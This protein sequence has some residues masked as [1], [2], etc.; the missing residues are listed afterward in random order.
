MK[1]RGIAVSESRIIFT[2][3]N[4]V[5]VCKRQEPNELLFKILGPF[6][7]PRGVAMDE[8]EYIYVA[9]SNN[10]R[11]VKFHRDGRYLMQRGKDDTFGSTKVRL[12]KPYGLH[13]KDKSLYVCDLGNSWIQIFDLKLNLLYRLGEQHALQG[14]LHQPAGIVYNP[15]DQNFYVVDTGKNVITIIHI[16]ENCCYVSR[17]QNMVSSDQQTEQVFQRMRGITVYNNH[18]IVTQVDHD[19][20]VCLSVTGQMKGEQDIKYPT[21]LTVHEGTVYVCSCSTAVD[22]IKCYQ[23]EELICKK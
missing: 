5:K 16:E 17:I 12:R 21:A 2:D 10:D 4:L 14:F 20:V 23:F 13:I 15:V 11:I 6:D 22:T 18:I 3:Q 7:T 1:S 19:S 8:H 9:D